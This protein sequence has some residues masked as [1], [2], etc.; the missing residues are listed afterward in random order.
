MVK[1][2]I[3]EGDRAAVY[4]LA[5][6]V[7]VLNDKYTKG[8]NLAYAA[9]LKTFSG[10]PV[11]W[12]VDISQTGKQSMKD[13]H[14]LFY[15]NSPT[16]ILDKL[17]KLK[18]KKHVDTPKSVLIKM[19][20]K[21]LRDL[22]DAISDHNKLSV[23][24]NQ[25]RYIFITIVDLNSI[26]AVDEICTIFRA[27]RPHHSTFNPDCTRKWDEFKKKALFDD[28]IVKEAWKYLLIDDI[29]ES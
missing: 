21:R 9:A 12:A 7:V 15:E 14:L 8:I 23:I 19:A 22:R 2:K 13:K 24:G 25:K 1:D 16:P 20:R 26:E 5:D 27:S 4:K 29:H 3:K 17:L 11:I 10:F 6:A 18:P 28:D